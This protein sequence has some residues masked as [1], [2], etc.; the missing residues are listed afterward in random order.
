[1]C[2][3]LV[4]TLWALVKLMLANFAA[5]RGMDVAFL[6]AISS[7]A[8]TLLALFL[9]LSALVKTRRAGGT[10]PVPAGPM[11]KMR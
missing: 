1:M 8:L 11:A 9:V 4:I 2:F 10:T 7:V 6:N 5:A 3:V